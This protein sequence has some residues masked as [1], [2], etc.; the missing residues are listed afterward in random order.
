MRSRDEQ[1]GP[2]R[3]REWYRSSFVPDSLRPPRIVRVAN[4]L[5]LSRVAVNKK[6]INPANIRAPHWGAVLGK[7]LVRK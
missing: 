7:K 3:R 6:S 4:R 1:P 5:M 2:L